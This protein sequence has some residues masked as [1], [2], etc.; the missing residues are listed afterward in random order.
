[1]TGK[2]TPPW[3]LTLAREAV[4]PIF[5]RLPFGLRP[6]LLAMTLFIGTGTLLLIGLASVP[7]FGLAWALIA[8]LVI[9]MTASMWGVRPALLSLFLFTIFGMTAGAPRLSPQTDTLLMQVLRP[10]LFAGCGAAAIRLVAWARRMQGKAE[11]KREVVEALQSVLLPTALAEAAGYDLCG[12]SKPAHEEEEVGGDFYDFYPAGDGR[13]CLVI[14]DV[15]GHGKEAAASTAL[16][17]YSVR[18]F[19]STGASPAGVIAQV[20]TL[21]ETQG[22]D[23][24]TASLFVGLLEPR[25]GTL[26]YASAGHEPPLL[27]RAGGEEEALEVTGPVLGTGFGAAYEEKTLELGPQDALLLL[28][29]GVSEARNRHGEFLGSAG[30]WWMLRAALKAAS[31]QTALASFDRALTDYIG[32]SR[33][34]DIALLLLRRTAL[35]GFRPETFWVGASCSE[36]RRKNTDHAHDRNH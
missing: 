35:A 36:P 2:T 13:Y 15:M 22:L 8:L 12:L 7:H 11:T 32:G 25:S 21:L 10:L 3:A 20:N 24:G 5:P 4:R 17:R 23:F 31:S 16:L 30:T 6:Y 9:A 26:H 34:D 33:R 1:M 14:G 28:T 29:D 18:A 19:C 27:R